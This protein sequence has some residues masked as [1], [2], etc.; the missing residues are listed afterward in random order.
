MLLNVGNCKWIGSSCS[1]STSITK[2]W[3]SNR[4]CQHRGKFLPIAKEWYMPSGNPW[5]WSFVF[6][7]LVLRQTQWTA[8]LTT[9][10]KHSL[11]CGVLYISDDLGRLTHMLEAALISEFHTS[12]GCRNAPESGGEGGLNRK[13]H[14]G[15]PFFYVHHR[16]VAE[17]TN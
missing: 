4:S 15:P 11:W 3:R 14:L 1:G 16:G 2:L 5:M 13:K 6:S 7:R 12:T 10:P 8:S 9:W 17:P